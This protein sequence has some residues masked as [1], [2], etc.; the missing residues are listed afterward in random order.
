VSGELE[1]RR[2]F[3]TFGAVFESRPA[4][5]VAAAHE[6]ASPL[7]VANRHGLKHDPFKA[8]VV[9]RP[10][11][12]VTTL[13]PD[14]RVNLAPYS[15]F[16]GFSSKPHIVGFSS[17]GRKDSATNVG[18]TGEFVCN[19]ATWELREQTNTTSAA[20]GPDVDEMS[21]AGLTPAPSRLVAPPRVAESPVALECRHLQT[22]QLKDLSGAAV[23]ALLVI[24]Q[25]V[26]IHIADELIV[27]GMVDITRARPIARLGYRDYAVV[28]KV[29]QMTRPG[30]SCR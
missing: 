5:V 29:F 19:L 20:V 7:A 18:A 25:V 22:V 9:P 11:G 12:W 8:L 17:E 23:G 6:P 15:Y 30:K 24:G 14:G 1:S 10:I 2:V 3:R 4:S 26:G 28:E 16:N 13:A 21:L 27:D